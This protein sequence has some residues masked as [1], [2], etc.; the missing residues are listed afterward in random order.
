MLL[1]LSASAVTLPYETDFSTD[2]MTGWSIIDANNDNNTWYSS[3]AN[4]WDGTGY[5]TGLAYKYHSSNQANDWAV[6]PAFQLEPGKTYKVSHWAKRYNTSNEEHY[7]LYF[8]Q[9]SSE[10]LTSLKDSGE[11]ILDAHGLGN[12]TGNLTDKFTNFVQYVSVEEEGDYY[13]GFHCTSPS[14]KWYVYLTG[15]TV[16][17]YL[18]K[19]GAATEITVTPAEQAE[20]NATLS[21]TWPTVTD[22]GAEYTG[23]IL[24]AKIYRSNS[25]NFKASEE[26]YIGE[27]GTTATY[28]DN[29]VPR[30]GNWYYIVLPFDNN[31]VSS[32]TPTIA[33]AWVGSDIPKRVEN[34][35]A[36]MDEDNPRRII[37]NFEL[38]GE[39]GQNGGYVKLSDVY[40]QIK[41]T[42]GKEV[43]LETAWQGEP[44][45]IDTVPGLNYYQYQIRN[46]GADGVELG[47]S[48]YG[49]SNSI[50]AGGEITLPY[51]N[52]FDNASDA[53][54]FTFLET[55]D[56][57]SYH[58][59]YNS[60]SGTI[61]SYTKTSG[62]DSW[63]ITPEFNFEAGKTYRVSF[64]TYVSYAG[65]NIYKMNVVLGQGKTREAMEAGRQLANF[66]LINWQAA[67]AKE[68]EA[69]F[70]V[71]E[72]GMYTIGF[73]DYSAVNTYYLHLDNLLVE[74]F[75]VSPMAPDN[76]TATADESGAK[77][78]ELKWTNPTKGVDNEDISSIQ[79][80]EI[81]R[82]N[83]QSELGEMIHE[84][85]EA[86]NLVPGEEVT[87]IDNDAEGL[88][89]PGFYYYS[90]KPYLNNTTR[91]VATAKSTWVGS[92][93]EVAAVTNVV[94]TP[95]ATNEQAVEITFDLPRGKNGGY[96]DL[97]NVV[98][99]ITRRVGYSGEETVLTENFNGQT[100]P[101][102]DS[103]IPSL[104]AYIYKVYNVVNGEAATTGTDSK[105]VVTGGTASLPYNPSLTSSESLDLFTILNEAESS[106]AQTWKDSGSGAYLTNTGTEPLDA[107]LITPKFHLE[108]GDYRLS[109]SASVSNQGGANLEVL[110]GS[111]TTPEA[112]NTTLVEKD[113]VTYENNFNNPLKVEKWFTIANEGDYNIAFRCEDDAYGTNMY[114]YIRS[115]NLIHFPTA[116]APIR[117]EAISIVPNPNGEM[118]AT[119]SWTNPSETNKGDELSQIDKVE[120][121]RYVSDNETYLL[122]TISEGDNLTVGGDASQE[123]E[124]VDCTPGQTYRFTVIAYLGENGSEAFPTAAA[125]AGW[126]GEDTPLTTVSNVVASIN[127]EDNT[128]IDLNFTYPKG[129]HGGY[130]NL[131]NMTFKIERRKGSDT[132]KPSTLLEENWNGTLPY[133][134]EPDTIGRYSYIVYVGDSNTRNESNVLIGGGVA[135][136][137]FE[138]VL[139]GKEDLDMF[140]ISGAPKW[141][142][143]TNGG[144]GALNVYFSTTEGNETWAVTQPFALESG[145]PYEVSLQ[146][147]NSS[148]SNNSAR[149]DLGFYLGNSFVVDSLK[150]HE[151]YYEEIRNTA[152]EPKSVIINVP[153]SG[154]YY[155]GIM[156]KTNTG[157]TSYPNLWVK[158]IKIAEAAV[159]PMPVDSLVAIPAD[160]GELTVTLNWTNPVNA[161]S[162]NPLNQNI[163]VKV[164][165][166]DSEE[167]LQTFENVEPGSEGTF[168]IEV[169][170]AGIYNYSV[171]PFIDEEAG[172]AV[173]ITTP[174]IGPD[175]PSPAKNVGIEMDAN[176]NRI[177]SFEPASGVN[178]GYIDMSQVTYDIYRVSGETEV[179]I[180]DGIRE[181][182]FTDTEEITELGKYIYGVVTNYAGTSS[183][184]VNTPAVTCGFLSLPYE[185]DYTNA[186]SFEF[187]NLKIFS[188]TT[189]SNNSK[190]GSLSSGNTSGSNAN[191]AWAVTPPFKALKGSVILDYLFDVE[192]D[193]HSK[194]MEVYLMKDPNDFEG[195]VLV[196]ESN[197]YEFTKPK[198]G[199]LD[200]E[201]PESGI[202]YLGFHALAS[203]NWY[204]YIKKSDISQGEVNLPGVP[205][206]VTDLVVTPGEEGAFSAT[207]SWITP[208]TDVMGDPLVIDSV[209]ILRNGQL[210]Y[211]LDELNPGEED[212]YTDTSFEGMEKGN[213]FTYS[214]VTYAGEIEGL[215][216]QADMVWIGPDVLC[217]PESVS[218][219]LNNE[220]VPVVSFSAVD[221]GAH[222]GYIDAANVTYNVYRDNVK[223]AENITETSFID[224]SELTVGT[225]YFYGV[226]A[227]LND[228]ESDITRAASF[229]YVAP[230]ALPFV[231]S[232]TNAADVTSLW[233]LSTNMSVV[234]N[235]TGVNFNKQYVIKKGTSANEWAVSPGFRAKAGTL[236]LTTRV[237]VEGASN[238]QNV[239]IYLKKEAS[240]AAE[241]DTVKAYQ[242]LNIVADATTNGS[243]V[244]VDEIEIEIPED[245][246]YYI[247]Y[248]ITTNNS[249]WF[250]YISKFELEQNVDEAPK[251]P[252]APANV[253]AAIGDDDS[254]TISFDAVSEDVN[255]GALE[256]VTYNILR[257]DEVI[258]S[259]VETASYTDDETGLPYGEYV[260]GVQAVV[261]DEVSEIAYAGAVIFGDGFTVDEENDFEDVLDGTYFWTFEGNDEDG[262]NFVG[263]DDATH[264]HSTAAEAMAISHKLALTAGFISVTAEV[265]GDEGDG[266][267]VYLIPEVSASSARLAKGEAL[268]LSTIELDGTGSQEEV[269]Y[270]EIVNS[271]DYYIGFKAAEGVSANGVH[272]FKVTVK[273]ASEEDV[274][275]VNR[276]YTDGALIYDKATQ[277]ILIPAPGRLEVFSTNGMRVVGVDT[278]DHVNVSVLEPATYVAR[279]VD[280]DGRI[281]T[282][283]FVK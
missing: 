105:K 92:D 201:I 197:A 157:T 179:L 121:Y 83:A 146:A 150:N 127:E 141:Q 31:G 196:R 104:N 154:V 52:T 151:I 72:S 49:L 108:P 232:F 129:M 221:K 215:P 24:G 223:I 211:T 167:A 229:K 212:T 139:N 59:A 144:E 82:S 174:W 264:L 256:G 269:V 234:D 172:V 254:R 109:Y 33:T 178:G 110:L 187:W 8:G 38:P 32:S 15:F 22:A 93:S 239:Y 238:P 56:F 183:D 245:G 61:C 243:N 90:L 268:S 164:F 261:E 10:D 274:T 153:E 75:I 130:V 106:T 205:E 230:V 142:F 25:N 91:E 266:I 226:S 40:Y 207:L 175:E 162:G 102:V 222:G 185:P 244:P 69:I 78:V 85:T 155:L 278:A 255:G 214:V 100:F 50:E 173:S 70:Q 199:T 147:Y 36:T 192:S 148:G 182:T 218:V 95:S 103:T 67:Q 48:G 14:N 181:N 13:F 271:G 62:T 89:E 140:Y 136:I 194:G 122:T 54:L 227:V 137:P 235:G 267:E 30:A 41:R 28:T 133:V 258:A 242:A 158:K 16:E 74:E 6:S 63:A 20:L 280:A 202:Y 180:A 58:W 176:G 281:A 9:P 37:L 198:E 19:P 55:P 161:N 47:T 248:N 73:H 17:E 66:D 80:I 145:I 4:N 46:V 272:L 79:K 68:L 77:S 2:N 1:A 247:G 159:A 21:W 71:T 265:A 116:P 191:M 138:P 128:K 193:S 152:F 282:L 39:E 118:K 86:E 277:T 35:V 165:G 260:Y 11:A 117:A 228:T 5:T 96:V 3:D 23:S 57:P 132:T 135:E 219:A 233:T 231:Q 123:V 200:I 263:D 113:R 94:A 171:I 29:T 209:K 125:A 262:W 249:S 124:L 131:E 84:V 114:F 18:P 88:A 220:D 195:G 7:T 42:G 275:G 206:K 259:N 87:Y 51:I 169:A 115:M 252:A 126:I 168:T 184:R 246:V 241:G 217:A 186:S 208:D 190:P 170:E 143:Q 64:T 111:G 189:T 283:K 65:S 34:V 149:Q 60:N 203:E 225:T 224:D 97:S 213:Y 120:I 12:G 216:V 160:G 44:P 101:Y 81:Y 177:I 276:V 26:T 107:W 119:L 134:D 240:F 98:Y 250:C 273:T 43:I 27:S 279:F 270:G 99:K 156:G 236:K 253:T 210:I 166:E 163:T 112:F 53:A 237:S 76:F 45:Y 204:V 251:I 188:H 257:N